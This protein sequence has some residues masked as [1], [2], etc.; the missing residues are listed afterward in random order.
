MS[1]LDVTYHCHNTYENG[2]HGMHC[3]IYKVFIDKCYINKLCY[4][5]YINYSLIL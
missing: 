2:F 5:Y 4:V 3:I 1:I